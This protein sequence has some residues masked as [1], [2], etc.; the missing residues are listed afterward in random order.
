MQKNKLTIVSGVI[1]TL[2]LANPASALEVNVGGLKASVGGN[3]G[4]SANVNANVGG[5]RATANVGAL[6]NSGTRATANVGTG[7]GTTATVNANLG[8]GS[9]TLPETLSAR[10]RIDLGGSRTRATVDIN[11]D[12]VID[13]DV[14]ALLKLDVN[15]DGQLTALDDL[16]GDGLLDGTD[17]KIRLNVG[18]GGNGDSVELSG[19]GVI[20][21]SIDANV[22]DLIDLGSLSIGTPIP[23]P[24]E[25]PEPG[26]TPL[27][28]DF[29]GTLP[30]VEGEIGGQGD[31]VD[32]LRGMDSQ[33]VAA[34]KIKC[35]DVM[36]NPG[37]FD[38]TT[39]SICR[40][41]ASL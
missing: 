40:A 17:L 6:G 36:G 27:P 30:R 8:S 25:T 29:D 3:T 33:D 10:V 26:I 20:D 31:I 23:T 11:G 22:G 41:L 4:V 19:T 13:D 1:A 35:V 28:G 39:V 24:V 5:T 2:M 37:A 9:G 38:A 32:R 15:G 14:T 7:G 16:N 34:L 12:G 18:E 21:G